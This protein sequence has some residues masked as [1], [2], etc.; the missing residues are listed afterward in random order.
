M[1]MC[2]CPLKCLAENMLAAFV[3]IAISDCFKSCKLF[4]GCDFEQD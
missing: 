2:N 1:Q 3:S 4:E